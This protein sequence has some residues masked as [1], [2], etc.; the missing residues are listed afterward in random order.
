[1]GDVKRCQKLSADQKMQ[2]S[3][4][5]SPLVIDASWIWELEQHEKASIYLALYIPV[6]IER[7]K[8]LVKTGAMLQAVLLSVLPEIRATCLGDVQST[9]HF[10]TSI[11]SHL[12]SLNH[13]EVSGYRPISLL[14]ICS[15]MLEKHVSDLLIMHLKHTVHFLLISGGL[16]QRGQLQMQCCQYYITGLNFRNI[17]R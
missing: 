6:L 5:F 1:M 8:I 12:G 9:Q 15:K 7:L 14:P 13:D 11:T 16:L 2:H 3:L 10:K 4:P 17:M